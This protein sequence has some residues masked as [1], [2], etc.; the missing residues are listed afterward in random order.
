MS[1]YLVSR[2][3]AVPERITLHR[4]TEITA[5]H[6]DRHLEQVTWTNRATGEEQTRRVAGIFLM[7]GAAPN[8]EWLGGAIALDARGFV[9][10]GARRAGRRRLRSPRACPAS[11]PSATSA[12]GRSNGSPPP[13]VRAPW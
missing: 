11:S 2:I 12:P 1:E 4:T 8:T 6:G 5:L 10:T 13:S 3:E 7:L 9:L